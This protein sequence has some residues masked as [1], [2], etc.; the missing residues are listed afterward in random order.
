MNFFRNF[1]KVIYTF[2]DEGEQAVMQNITAYAD[3][4]EDFRDN[5]SFYRDYHIVTG[6]RPD[7]VSMKLY[8]DPSFHWT[9][10]LMNESLLKHGWPLTQEELEHQI[11]RDFNGTVLKTKDQLFDKFYIGETVQDNITGATGVVVDR[12]LKLGHITLEQVEGIFQEGNLVTSQTNLTDTITIDRSMAE[13]LAPIYYIDADDEEIVDFCPFTGPGEFQVPITRL[14]FYISENDK[15]KQIKV[16]RPEA[17]RDV[18]SA[19]HDAI[20]S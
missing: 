16:L 10:F 11:K 3:I 1:P 19:F 14:D 18:S 7:Q 6:E 17:V 9:L 15:L 12:D 13:H 5:A 2:G 8:G 20:G 4:V